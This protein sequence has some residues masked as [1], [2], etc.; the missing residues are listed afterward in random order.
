MMR[1]FK[2]ELEK[3]NISGFFREYGL[4]VLITAV[5]TALRFYRLGRY[6]L[7]LDE[8]FSTLRAEQGIRYVLFERFKLTDFFIFLELFFGNSEFI[9]RFYSALFGVLG[10][11]ALYLCCEKL[12]G[13]R[14]AFLSSLLLT[15]NYFHIY[16]SQ[17]ARYYAVVFFFSVLSIF[18]LFKLLLER[19][20][21]HLFFL[22]AVY[23]LGIKTH[24]TFYLLIASELLFL[25]SVFLYWVVRNKLSFG[26]WEFFGNNIK[27]L[28]FKFKESNP[29]LKVGVFVFA[30]AGGY[31]LFKNFYSPGIISRF[32]F[33][34]FPTDPELI[35]LR[36]K[37]P[38]LF[39]WELFE[40]FSEVSLI[41]RRFLVLL[42]LI[43][44]EYSFSQERYYLVFLGFLIFSIP[45]LM[46]WLLNPHLAFNYRYVMFMLPLWIVFIAQGM[47]VISDLLF[48][49]L[50]RVSKFFEG[51][52]LLEN[53]AVFSLAVFFFIYPS[54][55]PLCNRF[56]GSRRYAWREIA[57]ILHENYKEGDIIYSNHYDSLQSVPYYLMKLEGES[58]AGHPVI[59]RSVRLQKFSEKEVEV[60]RYWFVFDGDYLAEILG[61]FDGKV[62]VAWH[63][64]DVPSIP[65]PKGRQYRFSKLGG[66]LTEFRIVPPVVSYS[67]RELVEEAL[68]SQ[69][70][71]YNDEYNFVQPAAYGQPGYLEYEVEVSADLSRLRVSWNAFVKYE[72]NYAKLWYSTDAENYKLI[73]HL[74]GSDKDLRSKQFFD[75]PWDVSDNTL[76]LRVE[77][78]TNQ[79]TSVVEF[80]SR[81]MGISVH[82]GL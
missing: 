33:R 65:F 20:F 29:V 54:Y 46:I 21:K 14:L 23:F 60:G 8:I 48:L 18:F 76:Y 45:V 32:D 69:G 24:S 53:T 50:G 44:L 68:Y 7:W 19:D 2:L 27:T 31:F 5:A 12:W 30:L 42:F 56:S 75:I 63:S 77:L 47:I 71:I 59:Q 57:E 67:G 9:I 72:G 13:K 64:A 15:F 51:K 43:G 80:D 70:I 52:D 49:L 40:R 38:P 79:E 35:P 16:Y 62:W 81:F 10:V 61:N 1:I 58:I 25:I 3:Q 55:S 4:L 11:V 28:F 66:T 78:F 6:G 22:I 17:D 36:F 41:F 74:E 82:S 39:Y 37:L 26:S 34:W 73:E